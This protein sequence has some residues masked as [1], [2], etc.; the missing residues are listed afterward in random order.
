[1]GW[2]CLFFKCTLICYE[3]NLVCADSKRRFL[4]NLVSLA[5]PCHVK[6]IVSDSIRGIQ[7]CRLRFVFLQVMKYQE[8][9][10]IEKDLVLGGRD[11][12]LNHAAEHDSALAHNLHLLFT[13][14]AAYSRSCSS[15]ERRGR[16]HQ[17][18]SPRA[19]FRIR[20]GPDSNDPGRWLSDRRQRPAHLVGT[21]ID[22]LQGTEFTFHRGK[23]F[24]SAASRRVCYPTPR[25]TPI[26][27]RYRHRFR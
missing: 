14:C 7:S 25:E 4:T 24:L 8:K 19:G 1:M 18:S 13:A 21:K 2:E 15:S 3:V 16:V 12:R 27:D 17:L 9:Q 5:D 22:C 11:Q 26:P 20:P 23:L 10:R 6:C